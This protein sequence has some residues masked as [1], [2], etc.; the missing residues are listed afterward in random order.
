MN[1]LN[2][3]LQLQLVDYLDKNFNWAWFKLLLITGF[4]KTSSI[5]FYSAY[6]YNLRK[7]RYIL[8]ANETNILNERIISPPKQ[9]DVL[10][11]FRSRAARRP[12]IEYYDINE[13]LRFAA[14]HGHLKL[15]KYLLKNN[16]DT[17]VV[18]ANNDAA[19]KMAAQ[20]GHLEVVKYLL[21]HKANTN[22]VDDGNDDALRMAAQKGHLR[23]VRY[24][25]KQ[26]A[27]TNVVGSDSDII[28]S[29]A[30]GGLDVLKYLI[31]KGLNVNDNSKSALKSAV[32]SGKLEVVQEFLE[33]KLPTQSVAWKYLIGQ[34]PKHNSGLNANINML[35]SDDFLA[36]I[37]SGNTDLVRY[38]VKEGINTN[39]T[40][41]RM[42]YVIKKTFDRGHYEVLRYLVSIGI[43]VESHLTYI[44]GP[45]HGQASRYDDIFKN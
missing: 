21:Q 6:L 9:G 41:K 5:D 39:F 40:K 44:R 1:Q 25:I 28:I 8:T 36:A 22:V 7:Q 32:K 3:D 35:N 31:S 27:N 20:G 29:A 18:D 38:L 37:E 17:N 23:V 16:T 14:G 30:A 42:H 12:I 19:L 43:D 26:D 2:F 4:D 24:L 10:N 13:D 15:V 45:R 11:V 33:F 34:D